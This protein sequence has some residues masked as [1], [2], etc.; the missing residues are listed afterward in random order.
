[1]LS[2]IFRYFRYR[3]RDVC[4]TQFRILI[5]ISDEAFKEAEDGST[6]VEAAGGNPQVVDL[7]QKVVIAR[8]GFVLSAPVL[9]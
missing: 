1:M 2:K 4:L 6:V 3:R 8:G 7:V 9:I 5:I